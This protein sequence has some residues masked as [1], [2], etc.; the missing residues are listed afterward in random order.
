M[1][2]SSGLFSDG[3]RGS[4]CAD[5]LVDGAPRYPP[6]SRIVF[7]SVRS[8]DPATQDLGS[9]ALQEEAP[10]CAPFLPCLLLDPPGTFPHGNSLLISLK[11]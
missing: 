5:L 9:P 7:A 8:G 1:L 3:V 4:E 11:L 10:P 2:L 6:F